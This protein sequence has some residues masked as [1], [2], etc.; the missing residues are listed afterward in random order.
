MKKR[1]GIKYHKDFEKAFEWKF[2]AKE[3]IKQLKREA[4][5][6]RLKIDIKLLPHHKFISTATQSESRIVGYTVRWFYKPPKK[7]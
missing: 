1:D 7:Q 4:K 5:K 2:K 3:F 6:G